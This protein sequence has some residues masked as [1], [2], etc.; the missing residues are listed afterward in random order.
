MYEDLLAEIKKMPVIDTHEHFEQYIKTSE[1]TMPQFF[2]DCSC[3]SVYAGEMDY[4]DVQIL[5]SDAV[6]EKEQFEALLRME[7]KIKYTNSGKCMERIARKLKYELTEENYEMLSLA[8]HSRSASYISNFA[9][10]IEAYICNSAGHPIYGGMRGLKYYLD[11]KIPADKKMYRVLNIT[12]M[13]CIDTKAKLKDLEYV[14]GFEIGNLSE[15]EVACKKIVDGFVK[16]GIVGYKEVYFYFRPMQLGKPEI[17][18]AQ[19]EFDSLL[20][21]ERIGTALLDYMMYRVY[22]ILSQTELPLAVHTGGLLDTAAPAKEFYQYMKVMNDF[23]EIVFD[24]LH[25]NYPLF[26]DYLIALRSCP[27]T[28]ANAT[29][30]TKSNTEYCI[31]AIGQLIDHISAERCNFFGGDCTCAGEAVEAALEQTEEVLALGLERLIKRGQ[32]GKTDALEIARMWLYEN[33]KQLYH[34]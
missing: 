4:E 12:D 13:H 24:L 7:R 8:F 30:I 10:N 15:W 1:C 23:P 26:E 21:G 5:H 17:E 32:L 14:A 19:R 34:L 27:N 6:T 28:F 11:Y 29:W 9:E 2:Y 31:H 20:K 18:T 16:L 25:L 22:E 3:A 33:P